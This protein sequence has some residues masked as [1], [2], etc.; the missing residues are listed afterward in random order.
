MS[1]DIQEEGW[2]FVGKI[3]G[4]I[5]EALLLGQICLGSNPRETPFSSFSSIGEQYSKRLRAL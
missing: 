4:A 5:L 2:Y 3:Y 1:G